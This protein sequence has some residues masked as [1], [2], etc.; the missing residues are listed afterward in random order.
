VPLYLFYRVTDE[1]RGPDAFAEVWGDYN[2]NNL[3]LSRLIGRCAGGPWGLL[4]TAAADQ[5]RIEDI[6]GPLPPDGPAEASRNVS[7]NQW[8]MERDPEGALTAPISVSIY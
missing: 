1:G 5:W 8:R 6:T 3:R 7:G 2:A 4:V